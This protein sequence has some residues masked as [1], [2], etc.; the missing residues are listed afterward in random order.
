MLSK[1]SVSLLSSLAPPLAAA[2]TGLSSTLSLPLLSLDRSSH[3]LNSILSVFYNPGSV[4]KVCFYNVTCL[5]QRIEELCALVSG[6][7]HIIVSLFLCSSKNNAQDKV[8]IPW[9]K[10]CQFQKPFKGLRPWR[11]SCWEEWK[12]KTYEKRTVENNIHSESGIFLPSRQ[13]N[14]LI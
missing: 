13:I 10:P 9:R 14:H 3:T 8:K 5:S 4:E 12:S 2:L 7:T 6:E 11:R 1:N